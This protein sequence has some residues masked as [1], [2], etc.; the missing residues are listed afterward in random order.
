MNLS[1]LPSDTLGAEGAIQGRARPVG[2]ARLSEREMN[3]AAPGP[4]V[5]GS[6]SVD[7][8]RL[9]LVLADGGKRDLAVGHDGNG[10]AVRGVDRIG[11]LA[12]D[13]HPLDISEIL[14][15]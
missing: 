12:V 1:R 2:W 13:D 15:T 14:E 3:W 5:R 8:Y 4:E 6:G 11:V 9:Q 10:R 7:A